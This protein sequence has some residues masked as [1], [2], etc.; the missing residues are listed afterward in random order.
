MYTRQLVRYWG[1]K[2]IEVIDGLI[3][4]DDH[5]IVGSF[6]SSATGTTR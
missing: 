6:V 2:P 3:N 5:V 4:E 1:R